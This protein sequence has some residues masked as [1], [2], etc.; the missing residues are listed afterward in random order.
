M[1]MG[2]RILTGALL[3]AA[4]TAHSAP[5]PPFS[6]AYWD[7]KTDNVETLANCA[8]LQEG[9]LLFLPELFEKSQAVD[10]M[11][12][13]GLYDYTRQAGLP[14]ADYYVRAPDRYLPVVHFDNGPDWFV[15][16]LV[17]ARQN[18]KVGY[19]DDSFRNHIAPQFDYAWQFQEGK[20]L[21]CNGCKPQ[22]EG[23]HMALGGGEWF[24]INKNGQ[25]VSEIR[26]GPF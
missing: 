20:A 26:S 19:W 12:W 5:T 21:V 10:G 24:Y 11:S 14:D 3:M 13:V 17:R 23:E 7:K 1:E 9:K 22:R 4:F 6:C 16:G 18:G 8:T 25:R 15:E 2:L